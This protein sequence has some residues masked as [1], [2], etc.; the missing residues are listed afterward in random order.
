MNLV[1]EDRTFPR[2]LAPVIHA[3]RRRD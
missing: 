2:S 1:L 3:A